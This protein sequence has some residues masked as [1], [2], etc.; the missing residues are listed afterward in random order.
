M[1][2]HLLTIVVLDSKGTHI[3]LH[4]IPATTTLQD[5]PKAEPRRQKWNY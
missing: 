5:N 1:I 3:K 4:D 2:G